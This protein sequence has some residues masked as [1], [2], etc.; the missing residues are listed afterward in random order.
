MVQVETSQLTAECNTWRDA[1]RK[2]RDE[3]TQHKMTLQQ[4]AAHSLSKDQLQQ[5]EHLQNQFHIQ[6]IN[7][8]DLKHAIKAQCRRIDY[9]M[10]DAGHLKEETFAKHEELFDQYQNLT[11]MLQ[12]LRSEFESFL[13]TA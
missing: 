3:F 6:L 1:L 4:A 2:Q 8:H 7:I 12:E 9:A 5:V 13:A 10:Q 11:V